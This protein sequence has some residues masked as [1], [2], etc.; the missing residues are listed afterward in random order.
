[1]TKLCLLTAERTIGHG[2]P[3][4]DV[5]ILALSEPGMGDARFVR[6]PVIGLSTNRQVTQ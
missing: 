6:L 5:P 2:Y 3:T 4:D 1:M